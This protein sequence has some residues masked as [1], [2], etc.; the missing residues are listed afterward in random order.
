VISRPSQILQAIAAVQLPIQISSG[1]Q[2]QKV[3]AAYPFLQWNIAGVNLPFFANRLSGGPSSFSAQNVQLRDSMVEMYLCLE[4]IVEG[5]SL[6][7][8]LEYTTDWVDAVYYAF[9]NKVKLGNTQTADMTGPLLLLAYISAWDIVQAQ[10][11][12][13]TYHAVKFDLTVHE[14]YAVTVGL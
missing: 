2:T 7:S 10:L 11:G 14:R 12:S 5:Q 9:A 4:T 3:T 13:T 8:S 1:V 6:A